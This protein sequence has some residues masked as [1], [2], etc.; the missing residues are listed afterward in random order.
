MTTVH[1]ALDLINQAFYR[2]P[3]IKALRIIRSSR[4]FLGT[5]Q[6]LG[7]PG[8]EKTV[9]KPEQRTEKTTDQGCWEQSSVVACLPNRCVALPLVPPTE[10][11]GRGAL[12]LT[13]E[14]STTHR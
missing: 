5:K 2:M 14:L 6:V 4:S 8:I 10:L 9:S 13:V 12:H 3:I 11:R 7:Q 1:E